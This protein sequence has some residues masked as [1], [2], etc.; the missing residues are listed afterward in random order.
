MRPIMGYTML[1]IQSDYSIPPLRIKRT[2]N[3]NT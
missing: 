1:Y 3:Q 2:E